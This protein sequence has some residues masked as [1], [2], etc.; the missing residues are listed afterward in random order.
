MAKKQVHMAW[1]RCC[2][3]PSQIRDGIKKNIILNKNGHL[4]SL[5]LLLELEKSSLLRWL[6]SKDILMQP[7]SFCTVSSLLYYLPSP[8]YPRTNLNFVHH[9]WI[10]HTKTEACGNIRE[11]IIAFKQRW[12]I[13]LS[14]EIGKEVGFE[15]QCETPTGVPASRKRYSI[16]L[17]LLA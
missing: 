7:A 9:Q 6:C 2:E 17:K 15:M 10:G 4:S 14:K 8:L 1:P 3:T 11:L 12:V 5:L 13:H 16:L